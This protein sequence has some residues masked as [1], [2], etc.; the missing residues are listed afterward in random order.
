MIDARVRIHTIF[1]FFF[2]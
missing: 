2:W 1:L